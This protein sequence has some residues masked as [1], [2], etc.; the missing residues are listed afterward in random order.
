MI[1]VLGSAN[2]DLTGRVP[3]LPA[4]GETVL[5]TSLTL[6]PGG[7]GANQAVAAARAGSEVTFIGRVGDDDYGQRLLD[8]LRGAGVAT[9]HVTIEA[10]VPT[11][12]ALIEVDNHGENS[13]AVIPG[14][15]AH[16]SRDDVDRGRHV[17]E[18]SGVL[19]LQLEIP[20]DTVRYAAQVAR[21]A[22]TLIVLNPAPAQA[23]PP[24][25]LGL[26]DVLVPNQEE[27]A[28]LSGFG[29]PLDA[30]AM[31]H[32]LLDTGARAVVVTRGT[33][34]AVVV[35]RQEEVDIPAIPVQAVDTTGAGDAFVGNLAHA[36]DSGQNLVE[37]SRFAVAAAALSV[38]RAG[39]QA[40]MPILAETEALLQGSR[41]L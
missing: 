18:T 34:G 12:V 4:P 20:L 30:A 24:E 3:H 26:V 6:S 38:Q 15:N 23:L 11:G 28:R 37:A 32:L 33:Q 35:T 10:T 36:L 40:S 41:S 27:V 25:L 29:W 9:D 21:E 2:L 17:I 8:S 1:T 14:A 39:A 31:S 5:G 19:L 16:V 13:I 7:K 22:A